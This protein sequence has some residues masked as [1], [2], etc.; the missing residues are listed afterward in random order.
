MFY[1][2]PTMADKRIL[3]IVVTALN[4][5]YKMCLSTDNFTRYKVKNNNLQ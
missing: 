3:Y 2:K 1:P 4:Q 5:P